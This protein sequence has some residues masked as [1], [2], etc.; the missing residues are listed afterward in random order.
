MTRFSDSNGCR[1]GV[2]RSSRCALPAPSP[3]A[4]ELADRRTIEFDGSRSMC[5]VLIGVD[6]LPVGQPIGSEKVRR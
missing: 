2:V 6:C 5:K 4:L 3:E 1:V